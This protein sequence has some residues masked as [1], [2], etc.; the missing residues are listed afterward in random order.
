MEQSIDLAIT[1]KDVVTLSGS[2]QTDH[3]NHDNEAGSVSATLRRILSS[4]AYL[5]VRIFPFFHFRYV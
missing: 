5:D 1:N 3:D 2:L 4:D